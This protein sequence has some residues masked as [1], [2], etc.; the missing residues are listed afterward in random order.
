MQQTDGYRR[1]SYGKLV[2]V[3]LDPSS[4]AGDPLFLHEARTLPNGSGSP[5]VDL[6][7]GLVVGT[8]ACA[9][10][11]RA[12]ECIP[13]EFLTRAQRDGVDVARFNGARAL[14]AL[15]DKMTSLCPPPT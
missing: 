6:S 13:A 3:H 1:V 4:E 5:I 15:C 7:S 9:P 14:D 11:E 12:D 10:G 2:V 8:H